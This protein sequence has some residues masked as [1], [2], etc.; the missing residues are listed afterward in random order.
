MP[1]ATGQLGGADLGRR[2][3]AHVDFEQQLVFGPSGGRRQ[4]HV[5]GGAR[6][7][8]EDRLAVGA[9]AL[10]I[11]PPLDGEFARF[12]ERV[13]RQ[14]RVR[15]AAERAGV[16]A[17]ERAFAAELD[18]AV[19]GGVAAGGVGQRA[20]AGRVVEA[21]LCRRPVCGDGALICF[22][23]LRAAGRRRPHE[24][25]ADGCHQRPHQQ[26]KALP[27]RPPLPHACPK[28]RRLISSDSR[29]LVPESQ[30]L[31]PIPIVTSRKKR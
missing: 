23:G 21:E 25:R 19:R 4:V 11:D 30:A 6:A 8:I 27:A 17:R 26:V 29:H 20:R 1:G 3:F 13:R 16:A 10:P 22:I 2:A 7:E 15:F 24:Q 5:V 9:A 14:G 28:A 12:G 18:P 31:R